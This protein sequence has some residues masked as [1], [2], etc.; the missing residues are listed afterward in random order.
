[1]ADELL[2]PSTIYTPAI[3][4]L[5]DAVEVHAVAHITGG[6][7]P[8]NLPRVMAPDLD[9]V[10]DRP[11][12]PVPRIFTEIAEAGRVTDAEMLRVFNLGVGMVVL[13]PAGDVDEA[14]DVL[15][16]AGHDPFV[17]GRLVPG[18]GRVHVRT[19]LH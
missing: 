12:W 7:L 18:S 9:A 6:G 13:L 2:R 16:A 14:I 8:G 3:L 1:L 5:L 4:T 15:G 10:I 19:T 17:L 11:P